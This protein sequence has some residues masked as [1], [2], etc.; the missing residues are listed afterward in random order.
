MIIVALVLLGLCM[1]SFVNALVWRIY[2]QSK[3]K[4]ESKRKNH[5]KQKSSYSIS[6][7]RSMCP[8]CKH[9]LAAKDL[10]PV[11]SWL[12]LGG[13]C[14]YCKKPISWQYPM[15]EL[16]MAILFVASYI[17]W[18]TQ[19]AGLEIVSF[20]LWLAALV[21]LVALLVYD[22]RWM[23]LPN[24]IVFPLAWIAGA[25]AL[26]NIWQEGSLSSLVSAL[27]GVAIGGGIFY[28]IFQVSKG[29][30]IGGGDVK[31]GFVL[32]LL[33]GEPD[34]ALLMLFLASLLGSL[35][36]IPLMIAKK[37]TPKTRVPFGPFLI[38]SAIVVQLF[39]NSITNWYINWTLGI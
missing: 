16:A 35:L 22:L 34:Q 38:A 4:K 31:L 12:S 23:L 39:G 27:A 8:S 32:G 3:E 1:G 14:R 33:L 11:L 30:W 5:D 2:K 9:E 10:I 37:V 19:V 6:T 36:V 29:K 13:K 28:V 15:V 17:F 26:I 20:V 21:G 18:P 24:R 25:G 7:G